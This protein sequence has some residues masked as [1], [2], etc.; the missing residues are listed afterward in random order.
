M[1]ENSRL[2][3]VVLILTYFEHNDH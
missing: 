2:L 3:D 1:S